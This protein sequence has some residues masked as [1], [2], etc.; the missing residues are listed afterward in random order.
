MK[1]TK[2]PEKLSAPPPLPDFEQTSNMRGT[3]WYYVAKGARNGPLS[4]N[5]IKWL[6][7]QNELDADAQVWRKGMAD[8]KELRQTELADVAV[9]PPPITSRSIGNGY[10]WMLACLP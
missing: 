7:A 4:A 5:K 1:E 10:V 2:M 8:W 3:E 9:Q 6:V